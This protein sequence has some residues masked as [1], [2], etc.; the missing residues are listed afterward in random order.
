MI[1][2]QILVRIW[3]EMFVDQPISHQHREV[4]RTVH[5]ALCSNLQILEM[6]CRRSRSFHTEN[7]FFRLTFLDQ[8][9]VR[10]QDFLS[11]SS[12]CEEMLE[13]NGR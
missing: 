6:P 2:R 1:M 7:F 8:S 5:C 3:C 13:S 12:T 4:S 10:N 9:S 11:R